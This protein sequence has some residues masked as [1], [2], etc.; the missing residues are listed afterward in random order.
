MPIDNTIPFPG[1]GSHADA[2]SDATL[3]PLARAS[4]PRSPAQIEAARRNGAR[5]RGPVTPAGKAISSRNAVKHGRATEIRIT[6][7]FDKHGVRLTVTDNG[8]GFVPEERDPAPATGEHLGLLT[9]RERAAR[10]RG[11]LALVSSPG[12]GTTIEAAVP[13]AAE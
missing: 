3:H 11:R 8:C 7:S 5:S 12:V 2:A 9:M 1:A 6:L 10:L 4:K 13:L